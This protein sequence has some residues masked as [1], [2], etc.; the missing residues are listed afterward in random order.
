[1]TTENKSEKRKRE[2][3][4]IEQQQQIV[5]ETN[6]YI[7]YSWRVRNTMSQAQFAMEK[8]REPGRYVS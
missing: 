2:K 7:L 8:Y 5:S 3:A 6:M 1:M 4:L